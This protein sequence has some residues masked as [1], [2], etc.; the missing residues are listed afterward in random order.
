MRGL[1]RS[2]S[3]DRCFAPAGAAFIAL[4]PLHADRQSP[5]LQHQPYLP[6]C[7]FFRNFIYLDVERIGDAH[8]DD[9]MRREIEDLRD[10][11][12]VETSAWRK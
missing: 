3:A 5:A 6:Q 8:L 4:N 2:G 11:E 1:H 7:A 10:S 9:E 12:F